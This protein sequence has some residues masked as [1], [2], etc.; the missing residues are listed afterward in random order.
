MKLDPNRTWKLVEKRLADERDPTLRRNLE[1]VLA[2]MK[3]EA[4]RRHRG[5]GGHAHREA[6]LH[7]LQQPRRPDPEPA[8]Q[9]G[10]RAPLLRPHDRADGRVPA[11][12]RVRPRDRRRR[13]RVHRGHD[14]DGLPG[15]DAARDGDRR[16]RPGRL[17]RGREPDGRGVAG[18][19]G[20]AEADGRGGLLGRRPVRGIAARKIVSR[21]IAPLEVAITARGRRQRA[22]LVERAHGEDAVVDLRIHGSLRSRSSVVEPRSVRTASTSARGGPPRCASRARGASITRYGVL[23][24]RAK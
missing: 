18:R 23:A 22:L 5:R 20:R 10:R 1:L 6:A 7:H 9:Q 16:G 14:A 4:K 15:R 19:S 11:R 12:V 8:R 24:P 17:L 13:L 3:A 21:D 2:H